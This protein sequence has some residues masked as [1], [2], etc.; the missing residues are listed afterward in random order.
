MSSAFR[1]CG[2]CLLGL[3]V[4]VGC[5]GCGGI[6]TADPGPPPPHG[7]TLVVLP[8]GTCL[9]E[10]VKKKG[11]EPITAEVTFY[12]YKDAYTPYDPAPTSGILILDDQRQ[13]SLQIDGDALVTPSGP[14]LFGDEEVNGVLSV[15]FDGEAR[16]IPLRVR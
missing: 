4:I 5:G 16:Q 2:F 1:F 15:E 10:V 8:D 9:I 11:N 14:A 13:V 7:G 6:S 12:F 3:M